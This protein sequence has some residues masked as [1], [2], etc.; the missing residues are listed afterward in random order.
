M[1]EQLDK[2]ASPYYRIDGV[3]GRDLSA[4]NLKEVYSPEK[5]NQYLGRGLSPAR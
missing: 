5:A 2:I 1:E 4:Q 3:V